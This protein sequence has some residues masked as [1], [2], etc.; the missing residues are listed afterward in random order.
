M[1]RLQRSH[2]ALILMLLLPGPAAAGVWVPAGPERGAVHALALDPSAPRVLYAATGPGGVFKS[3]SSGAA[4]SPAN[5]GIRS[6]TV[7]SL[8]VDPGHPGTIYAGTLQDGVFRSDD[9]GAS[10]SG[11]LDVALYGSAVTSLVVAPGAVYA[12]AGD[13]SIGFVNQV[14]KSTD[15]GETWS[16][17]ALT[18]VAALALDPA[19]PHRL[20]AALPEQGLVRST[21]DG[22]TWAPLTRGLPANGSATALVS[23]PGAGVYAAFVGVGIF[24]STDGGD[25][26]QRVSRGGMGGAKVAALV[27]G[28][29]STLYAVTETG[30]PSSHGLL[31]ST[32]GGAHWRQAGQGLP[33]DF[34]A[35]AADPHGTAVYAGSTALGVFRSADAGS[36]WSASNPGLRALPASSVLADPK[37]PGITYLTPLGHGGLLWKT[38][39]GGAT[40]SGIDVLDPLFP[41]WLLAVDPQRPATLY[42]TN[43]FLQRSRNGGRTWSF[44][45]DAPDLLA[46][47]PGQPAVLYRYLAH[48]VDRST[49]GGKT[50][51]HDFTP[52]CALISLTVAPSSDVFAGTECNDG[53]SPLLFKRGQGGWQPVPIGSITFTP[54]FSAFAYVAADPRRPSTVYASIYAPEVPNKDPFPQTF[55]STDGGLSWEVLPDL[56]GVIAFSFAFPVDEPETVYAAAS[57]NTSDVFVSHDGGR[58]WEVAGPGVRGGNLESV[59]AGGGNPAA[60]YVATSGGLYRLVSDPP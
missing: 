8:A 25:H 9:G 38:L 32:D 6:S 48:Q 53:E 40:W 19:D 23:V 7:L 36:T 37:R 13:E 58:G 41:S 20:Y 2:L 1:P 16:P 15:R 49:D 21:D 22:A 28:P 57:Y 50:W 54:S 46:I 14:Y 11:P 31:R 26:W 39:D 56:A 43:V 34:L 60:V 12:V 59:S 44:L 4:W 3:R 18:H 27:A 24:R 55:R 29:P 45:G 30:A 5:E 10:W 51:A 33:A 42:L 17:L 35:L 47:D 52:P